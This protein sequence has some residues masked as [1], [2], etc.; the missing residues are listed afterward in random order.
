MQLPFL[1][2]RISRGLG[3]AAR[4]IGASYDA[5]RPTSPHDP[6]APANRFLRLPAAFSPDDLS[7]H[8]PASYGHAT[9]FG[10]FDSAYTQPGDY[11]KGPAGTFFIVAQQSLLPILCVLASRT[12]S[13]VRPAAPTATGVNSYGGVTLAT[14]TPLITG[15]PGSVLSAGTGRPGELPADGRLPSWTVLLPATPVALRASDIIQDDL[16]RTYVIGTAE[17]TALGWRILAKQAAT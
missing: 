17:L 2:D 13:V 4:V 8:Q 11:L 9:W 1:Q 5:Y 6:V 3:T 14:S 12:L 10:L 15:W 7:F 16:S